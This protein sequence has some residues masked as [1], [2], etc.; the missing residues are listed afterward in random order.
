MKEI[1]TFSRINEGYQIFLMKRKVNTGNYRVIKGVVI[2]KTDT[3]TSCKTEAYLEP[4]QTS[5]M[6]LFCENSKRLLAYYH[7]RISSNKRWASKI[8]TA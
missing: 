3:Q 1:A 7:Y 6:E 2:T 4:G 8:A 5:I